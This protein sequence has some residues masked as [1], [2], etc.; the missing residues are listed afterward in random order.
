MS[1]DNIGWEYSERDKKQ[2]ALFDDMS[3]I[4]EVLIDLVD[5]SREATHSLYHLDETH[6]SIESY[7]QV[8]G[9]EWDGPSEEYIV[10]KAWELVA[11]LR[12]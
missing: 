9:Q 1:L 11:L 3:S 8:D 4:R 6:P 12:G 5:W 10:G 2:Q 7:I